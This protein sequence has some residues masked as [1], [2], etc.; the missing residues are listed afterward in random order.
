MMF[1]EFIARRRVR[2]IAKYI[3]VCLIKYLHANNYHYIPKSYLCLFKS[4][5]LTN[6]VH[7]CEYYDSTILSTALKVYSNTDNPSLYYRIC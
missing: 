5:N 3:D 7:F 6:I 2:W 4:S 1:K